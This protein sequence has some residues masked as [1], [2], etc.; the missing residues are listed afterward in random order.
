MEKWE[1]VAGFGNTKSR[2]RNVARDG[3]DSGVVAEMR[4]FPWKSA[5]T[6]QYARILVYFRGLIPLEGWVWGARWNGH[7]Y[8]K[9]AYGGPAHTHGTYEHLMLITFYGNV[10]TSRPSSRGV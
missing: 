4:G 8:A 1:W 2:A 7:R 3:G 10:K 9:Y 5:E 6:S